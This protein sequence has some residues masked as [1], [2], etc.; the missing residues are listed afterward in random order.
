MLQH[1]PSYGSAF[2]AYGGDWIMDSGATSHV[3][4][5]QGNLTTSH[6]PFELKSHHII[7]GNGKRLPVV[8][9]GTTQLTPTSFSLNNVLVSLI[10]SPTSS[11]LA[12][13]FVITSAPLNLIHL[14]SL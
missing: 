3:T 11:A 9:T 13:S 4:G 7:V 1:A 5:T 12:H 6:S 10:S 2:P 14:A 8:A